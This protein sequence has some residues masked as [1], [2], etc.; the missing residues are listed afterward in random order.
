MVFSFSDVYR[1]TEMIVFE[2]L[3]RSARKASGARAY[4]VI[5]PVGEI[6]AYALLP[7]GGEGCGVS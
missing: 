2:A 7:R 5:P 6:T 1:K 3:C 4:V